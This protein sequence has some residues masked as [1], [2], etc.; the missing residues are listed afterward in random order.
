LKTVISIENLSK[1]YRLGTRST[2][3]LVHDINQWLAHKKGN[4]GAYTRIGDNQT[5]SSYWAL[6][7]ISFDLVEGEI[8]GVIGRNGAGKS[9]LLKILSKITSPT[10]GSVKIR[11]KLASLLEVG[12]GFHPELSGRENIYING[13]ILGMSKAEINNKFE[14]ITEFAAINEFIDT[15]VKR[16]SSG[17]YIRLAFS[18]AAHLS[19]DI[20]IIDEVLAVGDA[21]FQRKC[22]GKMREVSNSGRTIIFVSHN[23]SAIKSLCTKAI[24]LNEGKMQN[25]PQQVSLTVN[26]YMSL[27]HKN[28]SDIDLSEIE[29]RHGNYNAIFQRLIIYS[30][31][32]EDAMPETGKKLRLRLFFN[33]KK[34]IDNCYFAISFNS[35]EGDNKILLS[36]ELLNKSYNFGKGINYVDCE[37]KKNPLQAGEYSVSIFMKSNNDIVDWIRDAMV[38]EIVPGDFYGTGRMIENGNSSVLTEQIWQ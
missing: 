37:L 18:V 8:L 35:L 25:H 4:V 16:Y 17:M 21:E 27:I 13:A 31:E 19:A 28:K 10:A 36:S 6:K 30:G 7:D 11:G 2:G 3:T 12:T 33:V 26:Q 22:L 14:Q 9:T 15:P 29:I 24:L 20:I 38:I 1:Y 23:M 32:K 34:I 5:S